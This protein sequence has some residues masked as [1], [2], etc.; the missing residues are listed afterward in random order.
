[1]RSGH[2]PSAQH[3][4]ER[5]TVD[6]LHRD[7]VVPVRLAERVDLDDVRMREPGRGRGL[8]PKALDRLRVAAAD[9]GQDLERHAAVQRELARLVDDAHPAAPDLPDDLE[10]PDRLHGPW[11]ENPCNAVRPAAIHPPGALCR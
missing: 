6:E 2:F 9:P 4:L 7:E 11:H 1:M 10:V 5:R 3:A 8:A